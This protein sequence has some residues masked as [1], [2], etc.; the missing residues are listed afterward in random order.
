MAFR[1]YLTDIKGKVKAHRN[2][3][4]NELHCIN[5]MERSTCNHICCGQSIGAEGSNPDSQGPA[6]KVVNLLLAN[7]LESSA[8]TCSVIVSGPRICT[9]RRFLESLMFKLNHLYVSL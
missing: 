7:C 2:R 8:P 5:G 9:H 4:V 6:V 1:S 3:R